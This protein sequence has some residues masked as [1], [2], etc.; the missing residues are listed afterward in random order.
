MIHF[1]LRAVIAACGLWLA[2]HIVS[3]VGYDNLTTLAIAG[4]LLGVA[5]AVVRPIL[6]VVTF[7]IT[8]VTLGLFLIVVNAAMIGL[9]AV[10]LDGFHVNGF[11]PAVWT[12]IIVG[13]TGWVGSWFIGPKPSSRRN[14]D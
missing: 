1:L 9:V 11:W 4:L 14:R 12:T 7:P 8:I 13:I 3:G 10:L 5:N 6:T 2:A